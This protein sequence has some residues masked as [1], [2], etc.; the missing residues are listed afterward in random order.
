MPEADRAQSNAAGSPPTAP[1]APRTRPKARHRRCPRIPTPEN[2]RETTERV[3]K[4]GNP[5]TP[6][7]R[8]D[9][10]ARVRATA[11]GCSISAFRMALRRVVWRFRAF[12]YALR[13]VGIAFSGSWHHSRVWECASGAA[14][15]VLRHVGMGFP[16]SCRHSGG[17]G[18][19][20]GDA[21]PGSFR[22]RPGGEESF[23]R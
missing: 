8:P 4:R 10:H 17:R 7:R 23:A 12:G 1:V 2:S 13:H 20:P 6:P 11:C 18:C 19:L 9:F 5:A 3:R 16:H 22:R 21:H 15:Y 14:G